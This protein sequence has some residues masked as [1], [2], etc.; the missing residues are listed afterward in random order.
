MDTAAVMMN[1]DLVVTTDTAVAH[2][3]GALGVPVWVALG[4]GADWRFLAG[5]EDI[6]WYPTMRLFRQKRLYE[7][8]ELFERI[9]AALP[10]RAAT[11]APAAVARAWSQAL[12]HYESGRL[13][14]AERGCRQVV[15]AEPCHAEAVHLLGVLAS[16]AG[17]HDLVGDEAFG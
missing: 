15:G 10:V 16:Q 4:V 12:G 8:E 3:A 1:L 6:P 11:P 7:W 2:L 9:A 14:E 5:R 17:R 13:T